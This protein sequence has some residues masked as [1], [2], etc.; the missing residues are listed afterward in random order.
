MNDKLALI[1]FLILII[2]SQQQCADDEILINID[3]CFSLETLIW[4]STIELD[5]TN[6]NFLTRTLKTISKNG[7]DLDFIRLDNK[8]LQSKNIL[9]SKIYISKTCINL[10]K[11]KLEINDTNVGMVMIVSNSND[12]TKNG[13]P[14]T[15]FIIRYTGS[16]EEKYINSTTYDFSFCNEDPI[17]LNHSINV[18]QIQ[19]FKKKR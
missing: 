11:E 14:Q 2:N 3:E 6:I 17:L 19:V 13:L 18:D 9:K 12:K 15:Y 5:F 4:N 1:L 16:D 8:N 7:Y 10:I